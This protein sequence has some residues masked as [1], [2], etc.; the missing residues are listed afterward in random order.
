M[1]SAISE[2][3]NGEGAVGFVPGVLQNILAGPDYQNADAQTRIANMLVT[4]GLIGA[5][6]YP[7]AVAARSAAGT[8][9]AALPAILSTP[10]FQAL[11]P[12]QQE[13]QAKALGLRMPRDKSGNALLPPVNAAKQTEYEKAIAQQG[14]TDLTAGRVSARSLPLMKVVNE[15]GDLVSYLEAHG[16][17]DIP[18]D[19][20]GAQLREKT[21]A[22]RGTGVEP[23]GY[24]SAPGGVT[25][26][27]EVPGKFTPTG[28][29]GRGAL[30]GTAAPSP[31]APGTQGAVSQETGQWQPFTDQSLATIHDHADAPANA[32]LPSVGHQVDAASPDGAILTTQ[33]GVPG[34]LA[35]SAAD[36]KRA[37][38]AAIANRQKVEEKVQSEAATQIT[39]TAQGVASLDAMRNYFE[40]SHDDPE[41]VVSSGA[42][43]LGQHVAAMPWAAAFSTGDDS[44]IHNMQVYKSL[45]TAAGHGWFRTLG[46]NRYSVQ[47]VQSLTKYL[48]NPAITKAEGL[49]IFD[50]LKKLMQARPEGAL[51]AVK[52]APDIIQEFAQSRIA[53]GVTPAPSRPVDRPVAKGGD[54]KARLKQAIADRA[55]PAA[56]QVASE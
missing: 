41:N 15:G 32:Q 6:Q 17:H 22:M 1:G 2:A 13:A 48:D 56:P 42:Y 35:P 40:K 23:E 53:D 18:S 55:A 8:A 14:L 27:G 31:Y 3:A 37:K 45:L 29:P 16:I 51:D 34:Y 39:N 33:N 26:T 30:P 52:N 5:G 20:A 25:L 43:L 54:L 36:V 4:G 24:K 49:S 19:L 9:N 21:N 10:E 47:G 28:Q 44:T 12:D 11:P 46:G 7:A 50:G 38:V